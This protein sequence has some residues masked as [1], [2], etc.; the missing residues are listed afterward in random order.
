MTS[1]LI[2][3]R[4]ARV[5][6]LG[7]ALVLALFAVGRGVPVL[8]AYTAAHR[9]SAAAAIQRV[10][11]AEWSA[12]NAERTGR[13]LEQ[14][15][16]Q[17]AAYDAALVDG[18]TPSTASASL[19]ELVADAASS[20]DV[21]LGS[22]QFSAD[23]VAGRSILSRVTARVSASG[24]LMSVAQLLQILEQGPQLLAVRELSIAQA[25]GGL[26]HGH[27]ETLQVELLVEGLFRRQPT[28]VAR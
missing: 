25:Q 12:H 7:S 16:V 18:T 13:A 6:V 3:P 28:G 11:L 14:T 5:L 20:A 2:S 21:R 17:L 4:D 10:G 26:A 22:M 23:T 24:D 15:R 1:S 27:T 8:R 9:Q 19:A